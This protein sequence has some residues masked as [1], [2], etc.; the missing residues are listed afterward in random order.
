MAYLPGRPRKPPLPNFIVLTDRDDGTEWVLCRI[1]G[2]ITLDTGGLIKSPI[3]NYTDFTKYGAFEGPAIQTVNFPYTINL[4]ARG[5][6]LGYE[7]LPLVHEETSSPKVMA[8]RKLDR[9]LAEI[10]VPAADYQFPQKHQGH[11][12]LAYEEITL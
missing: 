1:S 9:T 2:R 3:T 10:R 11:L 8:R 7:I 6:R 12:G 5:G 4:L